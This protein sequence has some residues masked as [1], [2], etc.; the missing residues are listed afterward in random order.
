MAFITSTPAAAPTPGRLAWWWSERV[1]RV[2]M[3]VLTAVAAAWAA[4]VVHDFGSRHAH[5]PA[6]GS[7]NLIG[8]SAGRVVGAMPGWI[9]MVV[10]MMGPVALPAIRHVAASSLRWR[11]G[12]AVIEFCSVYFAMWIGAG[13][14]AVALTAEVEPSPPLL[15]ALLLV[16]AAWQL[17]PAK[18]RALLACHRAIPMPPTGPQ[19]TIACARF[20]GVHARACMASCWPVMFAMVLAP[21][22]HAAW[23][24]ALF[25]VVVHERC[26]PKP[27]RAARQSAGVLALA[28]AAVWLSMPFS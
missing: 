15:G 6:A 5:G 22:P 26:A 25:P 24:A 11:R 3:L 27:R 14:V 23:T 20:G 7:E 13:L 18:R 28:A 1:E 8:V 9:L 21:M 19:A 10:A 4:L 17:T 16:A 2:D 12:R